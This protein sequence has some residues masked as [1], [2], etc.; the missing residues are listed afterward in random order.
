M[1]PFTNRTRSRMLVRPKPLP[2]MAAS[3]SNPFPKSLIRRWTSPDSSR[4]CT[5]TRFT[6][7]CLMA[8]CRASWTTRKREIPISSGRILDTSLLHSRSIFCRSA[9]SL[10]QLFMPATAP[11]YCSFEECNSWD[12]QSLH[13]VRDFCRLFP[14]FLHTVPNPGRIVLEL[15]E[16]DCG[17]ISAMSLTRVAT[18]SF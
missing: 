2:C 16:F 8:L 4:S 17:L 10:H 7:L 9:Y 1:V 14:K 12:K 13:V 3:R 15:F 11:R 18:I 6:P 5:S